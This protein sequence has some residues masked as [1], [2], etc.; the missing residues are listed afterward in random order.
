MNLP[1]ISGT[2]GRHR[3]RAAG[4]SLPGTLAS[5]IRR[6]RTRVF[7]QGTAQPREPDA[8]ILEFPGQRDTEE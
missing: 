5:A 4:S 6:V 7:L 2:P 3:A 1:P 8:K